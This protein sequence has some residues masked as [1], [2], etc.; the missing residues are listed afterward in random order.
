MAAASELLK[1]SLNELIKDQLKEFRWELKN[2][3]GI[4]ASELETADVLDTVDRM[5]EHHG[6]DG[7]VKVT[8]NIFRKMNQ[9][10]LAELLENRVKEG[11]TNATNEGN[12]EMQNKNIVINYSPS[13]C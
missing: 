3:Y 6:P 8:L 1:D 5:V 7:A 2:H 11:K 9:N 4:S 12:W 13:S 10:H